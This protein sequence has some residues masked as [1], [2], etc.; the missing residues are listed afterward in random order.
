MI[1]FVCPNQRCG[2]TWAETDDADRVSCPSC[3][4]Q[5]S[6]SEAGRTAAYTPE[7]TTEPK[8]R[9]TQVPH[10][11]IGPY[12]IQELLGSGTFGTVYRGFDTRLKRF[13]AIKVLKSDWTAHP[14]IVDRFLREARSAAN[15]SH[16]NIVPVY[17]TGVFG[18]EYYIATAYID[19]SSLDRKLRTFSG[20]F[21][22]SAALVRDLARALAYAHQQQVVHRDI[23][24]ANVM[25]SRDG[26]PLVMDFGLARWKSEL[27][28][29]V[30]ELPADVK[31]R[32]L[33]MPNQLLGTPAYM[34]P[35]QALAEQSRIGPA[36]DQYSL[37]VVLYELL[38]SR[39]PFHEAHGQ[40]LVRLRDPQARFPS[41]RDRNSQVP[42]DLDAICLKALA[43]DPEKRYAD[44][45]ALARDL[46]R[47]LEGRPVDA[48]PLSRREQFRLWRRREPVVATLTLGVMVAIT[49]GAVSSALLAWRASDRAGAAE[50]ALKN[51]TKA[52]GQAR[53]QQAAALAAQKRAEQER[54]RADEKTREAVA[55]QKQAS[56]RADYAEQ[57]AYVANLQLIQQAWDRGAIAELKT[58]LALH[59]P[60]PGTTDRRGFEWFYWDR[61]MRICPGARNVHP[62]DSHVAHLLPI[63]KSDLVLVVE[64]PQNNAELSLRQLVSHDGRE[65]L[66]TV[67]STRLVSGAASICLSPRGDLVATR[68]NQESVHL[69]TV[70]DLKPVRSF[71]VGHHF[72]RSRILIDL[73]GSKLYVL[74]ARVGNDRYSLRR[75]DLVSGEPD[76]QLNE[77]ELLKHLLSSLQ[78]LELSADGSHALAAGPLNTATWWNVH[79]KTLE[80]SIRFPNPA[81][82]FHSCRLSADGQRAVGLGIDGQIV[83]WNLATGSHELVLTGDANLGSREIHLDRSGKLACVGSDYELSQVWNLQ[84]GELV[85]ARRGCA[86]PPEQ[87]QTDQPRMKRPSLLVVTQEFLLCLQIPDAYRPVAADGNETPAIRVNGQSR[88]HTLDRRMPHERIRIKLPPNRRR[89]DLL[90]PVTA[91]PLLLRPLV[92]I[93]RV[94]V[95][96][97]G[98]LVS[99]QVPELDLPRFAGHDTRLGTG[100]ELH[101]QGLGV[102]ITVQQPSDGRSQLPVGRATATRCRHQATPLSI[103]GQPTDA[104]AVGGIVHGQT[105]NDLPRPCVQQRD[106]IE[107]TTDGTDTGLGMKRDRQVRRGRRP[108]CLR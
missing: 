22:R 92:G 15:L 19:G 40:V 67:R 17:D 50:M 2:H 37:G 66:D 73:T 104:E 45:D 99:R 93:R 81:T 46:D 14:Q 21:R 30:D 72:S 84:T 87:I 18:S 4:T 74:N 77:L 53:T 76:W 63:P 31:D 103:K 68:D 94:P 6:F 78:S 27:V 62:P 9:S 90:E 96:L 80:R 24:P 36:S 108:R 79:T 83:V 95:K 97:T 49:V 60:R 70:P 86:L 56:E 25:L 3:G 55:A 91:Q 12:E 13:V 102:E 26:Q 54:T 57:L 16:P 39:I 8:A 59:Q 42:L 32:T 69:W 41:P 105:I 65:R 43:W 34:A 48:R 100:Q 29:P 85:K 88:H 51:E 28:E 33:T 10:T 20:D 82:R 7:N 107:S 98:H 23:K 61:L 106:C 5:V 52:L 64:S 89:T 47:W 35:E 1:E 38:T 101:V 58:R 71:A 44:C 75:F 11:T